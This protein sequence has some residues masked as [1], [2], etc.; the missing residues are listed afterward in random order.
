[1][2]IYPYQ[3]D[4]LRLLKELSKI[5]KTADKILTQH[6]KEMEISPIL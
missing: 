1:L 5:D 4:G 6:L 2:E 3:I